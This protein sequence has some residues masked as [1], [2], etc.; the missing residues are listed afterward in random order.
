MWKLHEVVLLGR[1]HAHLDIIYGCLHTAMAEPGSCDRDHGAHKAHSAYYL[2]IQGKESAGP[3]TAR[4]AR[5]LV[6]I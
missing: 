6:I 1:G 4:H 3:W 5:D 2:A